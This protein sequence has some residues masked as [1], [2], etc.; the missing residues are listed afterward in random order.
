M[1]GGLVVV[2]IVFQT[3]PTGV[4]SFDEDLFVVVDAGAEK[5]SK[6]KTR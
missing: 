5:W 2:K 3:S 4:F 6:T 1:K